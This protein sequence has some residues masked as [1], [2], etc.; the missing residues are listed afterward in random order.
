[1]FISYREQR[2]TIRTVTE[3]GPGRHTSRH[4]SKVVRHGG[5][6]GPHHD[7]V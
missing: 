4:D 5:G 3:V 2:K 7:Y 6:V 1:M